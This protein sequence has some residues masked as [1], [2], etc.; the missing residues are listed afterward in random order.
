M[1]N[2]SPFRTGFTTAWQKP[3][4]VITEIAWR[5]AFGA[6]ALATLTMALLRLLGATR[7]TA[8]DTAAFRG[9]DPML[10]ALATLHIWQH[11][12]LPLLRTSLI[13]IPVITLLWIVLAS[14]GR[15]AMLSRLLEAHPAFRPASIF[16]I[17]ALRAFWML[18]ALAACF[19]TVALASLTAAR[20]SAD[21]YRPN[22]PLYFLLVAILLPMVLFGWSTFNWLLSVAPIFCL[23]DGAT[24]LAAIAEAR[25]AVAE[26][27]KQFSAASLSY[28][29]LRL[30][31]LLVYIGATTTAASLAADLFGMRA[32]WAIV[33]LFS[34][35][36]FIAADFIY[37]A[38][39]AAYVAI[40]A[41]QA[42][43]KPPEPQPSEVP[44][45]V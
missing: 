34:L 19:T 26:H 5:W 32:A 43:Q 45:A 30:F 17:N 36:Y 23:R 20:F 8:G 25:S 14:I 18:A 6:C 38:R 31:I 12:R 7:I 42:D 2:P 9:G 10:M 37:V 21:P 3:N 11:L 13:A 1:S 22:L 4:L 28:G 44:V 39:L 27:R 41:P 40:L 33:I 29:L 35:I 16:A 24:S 15:S